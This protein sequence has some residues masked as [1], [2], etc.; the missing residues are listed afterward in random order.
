M[1]MCGNQYDKRKPQRPEN[2][3][4]NRDSRYRTGDP[5]QCSNATQPQRRYRLEEEIRGIRTRHY[6]VTRQTDE[7][8]CRHEPVALGSEGL[9]DLRQR[10]DC[11]LAVAAA[12]VHEENGRGLASVGLLSFVHFAQHVANNPFGLIWEA[13]EVVGLDVVDTP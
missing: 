11:G 5:R 2:S 7:L 9:D 10:L 3:G 13:P 12:V 1:L 6:G 8:V 4:D